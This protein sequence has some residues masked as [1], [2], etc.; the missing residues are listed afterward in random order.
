[1]PVVQIP[2]GVRTPVVFGEFYNTPCV[3]C[4]VV[5]GAD[6]QICS[7]PNGTYTALAAGAKFYN[8]YIKPTYNTIVCIK[9][10]PWRE[11]LD[12]NI[13]N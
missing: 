7:T 4:E 3:L 5:E 12:Y 11:Q 6:L 1:M 10:R 8:S 13:T 9:K 2:I